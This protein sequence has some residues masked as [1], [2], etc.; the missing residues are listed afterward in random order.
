M[1]FPNRRRPST[2]GK[3][4]L[5]WIPQEYMGLVIGKHGA[6]LTE[7]SQES[8]AV[9]ERINRDIY[10]SGSPKAQEQATQ[11]IRDLIVSHRFQC[12]KTQDFLKY[13]KSRLLVR[14]N[15]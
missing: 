14:I 4:K 6:K 2:L 8:G 15:I 12:I 7:I 10:I 3:T 5:S 13:I 1:K 11:M 9:L